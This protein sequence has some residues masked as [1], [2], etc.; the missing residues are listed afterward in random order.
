MFEVVTH[1]EAPRLGYPVDNVTIC[2]KVSRADRDRDS[3]GSQG[4]RR[5]DQLV[6]VDGRRVVNGH[7]TAA[8]TNDRGQAIAH[9]PGHVQPVLPRTDQSARPLVFQDMLQSRGGTSRHHPQGVPIEVHQRLIRD[10]ELVA[11]RGKGIAGVESQRVCASEHPDTYS[12]KPV[13][14]ECLT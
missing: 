7:F 5:V 1:F 14:L 3:V 9:P 6:Q 4:A 8:G 13:K 11:P 12:I 10:H 2:R